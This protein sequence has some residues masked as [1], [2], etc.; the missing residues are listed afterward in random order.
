MTTEKVNSLIQYMYCAVFVTK[1]EIIFGNIL[2]LQNYYK[3]QI[4]GVYTCV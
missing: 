1:C 2:I 4:C 3:V